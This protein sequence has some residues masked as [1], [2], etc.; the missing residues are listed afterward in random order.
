M[1]AY[2]HYKVS[3]LE[4]DAG[5]ANSYDERMNSPSGKAIK[6]FLSLKSDKRPKN[7]KRKKNDNRKK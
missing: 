2:Q 5:R 7:D 6:D 4:H 1:Q 3:G